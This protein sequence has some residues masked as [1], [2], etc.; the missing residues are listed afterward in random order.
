MGKAVRSCTCDGNIGRLI[1]QLRAL[2][3][4]KLI[5]SLSEVAFGNVVAGK[6][7]GIAAISFTGD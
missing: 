7:Y 2:A 5:C 3:N 4:A 1:G 6:C